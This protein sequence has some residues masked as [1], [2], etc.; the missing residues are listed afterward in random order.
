M[1]SFSRCALA[2]E[3]CLKPLHVS[4]PD[5]GRRSAERR[6]LSWP[7]HALRCRHLT[8]LRARRVRIAAR[9]PSG[10]PPRTRF[11]ELTPQLS[12]SRASWVSASSGVTRIFPYPSP[13]SSSQAGRYYR[14]GGVRSRPGAGYKPA[15]GHRIRPIARLSPVDV[16]SMGGP[17]PSNYTGDRCQEAVLLLETNS[18]GRRH[19]GPTCSFSIG[20]ACGVWTVSGTSL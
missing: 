20:S 15:R 18:A 4:P 11:G 19:A 17:A 14:P 1:L 5:K 6:K 7:R 10:A 13:A 16:P 9:A 2:S 12:S 3:L 8:A